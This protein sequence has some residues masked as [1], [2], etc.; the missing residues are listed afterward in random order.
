MFANHSKSE[1]ST[2]INC[3]A[4]D[5]DLNR[6]TTDSAAGE[7]S[8]ENK[9]QQS[10][11]KLKRVMPAKIGSTKA[12]RAKNEKRPS[13]STRFDQIGH[14]GAFDS[15]ND[16][17]R[18]KLEGCTQKTRVF[19]EKCN[20]HICFNQKNNCFKIFHTAPH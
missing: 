2:Q 19:C 13:L 17:T 7:G 1:R 3:E 18:C 12:K 4:A 14:F 9:C 6:I 16:S 11:H 10:A 20:V 5:H 15:N 8:A